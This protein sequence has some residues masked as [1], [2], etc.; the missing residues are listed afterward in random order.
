MKEGKLGFIICALLLFMCGSCLGR[1]VVEKNSLRVTSPD[2][3]KDTYECAI[4]NFGVP[5]YGGTLA[6]AV[7]YPKA[8]QRACRSFSDDVSFKFK[9]GAGLPVFLLVD[10]GG[11]FTFLPFCSILLF[12]I[13]QKIH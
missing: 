6:G 13:M 9:S 4:G 3:L 10:R 12:F 7:L 5:Q 11:K 1:F 8:N 2:N